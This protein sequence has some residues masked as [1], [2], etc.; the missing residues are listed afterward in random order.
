[1]IKSKSGRLKRGILEVFFSVS[2]WNGV[3]CCMLY[4]Q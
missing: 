4:E 2:M 1:M 3:P